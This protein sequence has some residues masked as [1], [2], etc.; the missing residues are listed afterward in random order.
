[1]VVPGSRIERYSPIQFSALNWLHDL[2]EGVHTQ[3][4]SEC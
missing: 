3:S 4:V 1:M 2:G